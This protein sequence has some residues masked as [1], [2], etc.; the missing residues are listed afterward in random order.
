MYTPR[1]TTNTTS[2][3]SKHNK[4]MDELLYGYTQYMWQQ[5]REN[6]I[7]YDELE[8]Y[9]FPTTDKGLEILEYLRD[10]DLIEQVFEEEG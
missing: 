4:I 10:L 1:F 3:T 8:E 2:N 5:N 6:D 9:Y 7:D